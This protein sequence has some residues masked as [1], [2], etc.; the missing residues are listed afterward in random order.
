MSTLLETGKWRPL[1]PL[2]DPWL[3]APCGSTPERSY[4][5][6][7]S[8]DWHVATTEWTPGKCKWFWD[9]A[10]VGET[11]LA[12]GVPTTKFRWTLQAE[13][14]FGDDAR[15]PAPDRRTP[16]GRLGRPVFL[17]TERLAVCYIEARSAFQGRTSEPGP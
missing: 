4:S 15:Y 7:D 10:L 17:F 2:R 12:T 6:T 16:A 5:L 3:T 13:T 9:G 1:L 11:T 14:E 8:S